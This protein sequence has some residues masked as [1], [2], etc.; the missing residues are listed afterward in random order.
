MS[1]LSVAA[2][3]LTGML[4]MP[5]L[6]TP[7]QIERG[8]TYPPSTARPGVPPILG[9]RSGD[10]LGLEDVLRFRPVFAF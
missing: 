2:N 9:S 6:I 4:T 8:M 7:F 10:I 1:L 3:S 5:K